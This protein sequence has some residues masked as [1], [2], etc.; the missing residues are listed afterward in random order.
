LIAKILLTLLIASD[1]FASD[2]KILSWNTFMLPKPIKFSLQDLRT[3]ILPSKLQGSD[4]DLMFFQESFIG[5]FHKDL[6]RALGKDFPY[7]YYLKNNRFL[8]PYLGSGLFLMSRYPFKILDK[9]YFTKCSGADCFASKGAVL[10]EVKLPSGRVVQIANTHL[11][12]KENAGALRIHQVKQIASMLQKHKRNGVAQLLV[13]DLNIDIVEPEFE[14]SLEILNMASTQLSGPIQHTSGRANDCYKIPGKNKEIVD[15]I[16]TNR[17]SGVTRSF[18]QVRDLNFEHG[19][20][21]CPMSDHH[22]I[23]AEFDFI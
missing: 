21:L 13:G 18:M 17:E 8:Y 10:I 11:Q 16:W 19:G 6:R 7:S 14:L 22:A 2:L 9:I 20:K 5:T 12:A 1:A 23:E 4:Y 3:K 15:H